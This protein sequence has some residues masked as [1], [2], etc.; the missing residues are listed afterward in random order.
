MYISDEKKSD[1]FAVVKLAIFIGSSNFKCE[2]FPQ[3]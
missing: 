2:M 1:N 3:T